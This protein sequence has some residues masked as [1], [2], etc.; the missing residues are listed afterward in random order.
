MKSEVKAIIRWVPASR[1]GRQRPPAPAAGYTAPARFESDPGEL[2]GVW[3]IRLLEASEL[4]GAEV[5]NARIGFVVPEAPH[6]LLC[7]GERFELMEGHKIVAKGVVL[8]AATQ[9]PE[10][11]SQFELA[12]LG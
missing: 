3:S 7:E 5:I 1:G 2:K 12:L 6:D 10:Q 8:P 9:V 4:H 11:I